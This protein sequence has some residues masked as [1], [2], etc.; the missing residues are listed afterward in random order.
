MGREIVF[1]Q[2]PLSIGMGKGL[3]LTGSTCST[4]SPSMSEISK[5]VATGPALQCWPQQVNRTNHNGLQQ[6]ENISKKFRHN[7]MLGGDGYGRSGRHNCKFALSESTKFSGSLLARFLGPRAH[8][9]R[10]NRICTLKI[11]CTRM[12]L[13]FEQWG[14]S[15]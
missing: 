12:W 5:V 13:L 4:S 15:K 2:R 14:Y 11:N 3:E 6:V 7:L 1:K 8:C 10:P 9:E